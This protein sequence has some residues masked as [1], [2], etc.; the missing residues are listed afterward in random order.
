MKIN[1]N[2]LIKSIEARWW[3][4]LESS[5]PSSK[6]LD[7]YQAFLERNDIRGGEYFFHPEKDNYQD[8]LSRL[9]PNDIVFDI[10]AGD[11]RF[12]LMMSRKVKK[13]YAIEINPSILSYA[14]DIIDN[15]MPT[16]MNVI[17]GN[18]FT[19]PIPEDVNTITCLMIHREHDLL[20]V[21]KDKNYKVI[22]Y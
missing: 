13:V 3:Q 9:D 22:A 1:I 21:R 15:N 7:E 6:E 10:G 2:K 14:L 4:E 19:Y 16:N 11:L 12:D 17:C 8:C 18:G 5:N 20:N